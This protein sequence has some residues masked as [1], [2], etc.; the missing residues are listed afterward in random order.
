VLRVPPCS[1]PCAR[2]LRRAR[3]GTPIAMSITI[4]PQKNPPYCDTPAI[5]LDHRAA[6]STTSCGII[7]QELCRV[8]ID[9]I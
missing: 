5:G 8:G 9:A 3:A 2:R 4:S 7:E 1:I 6:T